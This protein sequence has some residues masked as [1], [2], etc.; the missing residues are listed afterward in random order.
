MHYSGEN[1]MKYFYGSFVL[2]VA[3]L[4]AAFFLGGVSALVV[5]AVLAILEVSLSFDN[6]IVNASVLSGWD[7]KWRRIF[8]WFGLPVAVFG[9]RLLFPVLIVSVATGLG[10]V[11]AFSL[12]LQTPAEYARIVLSVHHQIAAFGG[13]FL[14]MVAFEFF[15]DEEKKHHW[16]PGVERFLS[17]LD[18]YQKAVGAGM[19]LCVL[20]TTATMI[21]GTEQAQF[22]VAGIYGLIT[23]IGVKFV[24]QAL[25]GDEVDRKRVAQGIGGFLY[26]EVLDASFSFDGVIGAFAITHSLVLIMIGL[27]IGAIFVRS[28]TLY[29][30]DQGT[31]AQYQ[32]L[33]HGAFWAIF[34]LAII[35]FIGVRVEIP[36]MVTGLLGAAFIGFSLWS[37]VQAN[38]KKER[39][40]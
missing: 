28:F 3:G 32:Y 30:T 8:L 27:A 23:Y 7:A 10:M 38:R 25:G 33:E 19:A 16:L 1:I 9:M 15:I 20:M 31:L 14:L 18:T 12:A 4:V 26:L 5:V 35:M 6:A 11:E 39:P 24:G 29:L 36:E 17:R 34:V 37:S 13:M 40:E 21:N 22:I 2:S